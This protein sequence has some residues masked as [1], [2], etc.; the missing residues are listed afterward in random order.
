MFI[1]QNT[2]CLKKGSLTHYLKICACLLFDQTCCSCIVLEASRGTSQILLTA[3]V[4]GNINVPLSSGRCTTTN[5]EIHILAI[6]T[7]SVQNHWKM[8]IWSVV[9]VSSVLRINVSYCA[10][11]CCIRKL[12]ATQFHQVHW[13]TFDLSNSRPNCNLK[14]FKYISTNTI[15]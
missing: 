15:L 9:I 6:S 11:Q 12:L 2:Q 5:I 1:V 8:K 7:S 4:L 14:W 10:V 3:S 13:L